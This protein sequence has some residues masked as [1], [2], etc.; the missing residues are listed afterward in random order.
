MPSLATLVTQLGESDCEEIHE[1]VLKQPVNAWTSLGFSAVGLL[2]ALSAVGAR[3]PERTIRLTFGL[4]MVATGIGSYLFHG[5]QTSGSHLLHDITFLAA[6]WF[7]AV[8][9]LNEAYSWRPGA[10]WIAFAVGV[11]V[12]TLVLVVF[13]DAT[14]IL[15]GI[16]LAALVIADVAIQRRGG[17]IGGW[18]GVALGTMVVAVGLLAIGRSGSPLCDPASAFQGHGGWHLFAAIA[19]G[20]YFMA[21]SRARIEGRRHLPVAPR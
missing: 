9:N 12:F 13:P 20:A 17:I 14:N 15:T 18:Y 11:G 10:G 19:L 6:V 8:M 4:L 5:P 3:G 1:A 16:T 2:I 7:L 21:T